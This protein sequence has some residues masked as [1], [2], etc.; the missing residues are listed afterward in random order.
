MRKK[1]KKSGAGGELWGEQELE[2]CASDLF[3]WVKTKHTVITLG[4]SENA[5]Y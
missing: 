3:T 4:I 1:N 5:D 2:S